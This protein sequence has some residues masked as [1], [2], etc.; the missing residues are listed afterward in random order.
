MGCVH[1][2]ENHGLTTVEEREVDANTSTGI[3]VGGWGRV[4]EGGEGGG[5]GEDT[6]TDRDRD[7]HKHR[8]TDR[9]AGRQVDRQKW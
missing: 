5:G 9:Q 3:R 8:E 7:R 1:D 2:L 6:Q 4:F